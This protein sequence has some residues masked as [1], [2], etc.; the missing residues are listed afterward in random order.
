MNFQSRIILMVFTCSIMFTSFTECSRILCLFPS[1]SRSHV[2]I[3]TALL[4]ELAEK[5]HEVTMLSPFPLDTPIKNYRD[6]NAPLF[7][8]HQ[9]TYIL[10]NRF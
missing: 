5:G 2:I 8:S 10:Y 7:E 1:P 9:G 3:A 4:Q 6:I